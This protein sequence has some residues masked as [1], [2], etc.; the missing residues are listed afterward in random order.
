M[1]KLFTL[2]RTLVDDGA[3][4]LRSSM[5][6]LHLAL[7]HAS[8]KALDPRNEI[9]RNE[10]ARLLANACTS[11]RSV[12]E[13]IDLVNAELTSAN[14]ALLCLLELLERS[15]TAQL[16]AARLYCLLAPIARQY[17]AANSAVDSVACHWKDSPHGGRA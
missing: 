11:A 8:C 12:N 16:S 2:D 3:D 10:L 1:S 9:N 7:G 15:E 17:R 13:L 14:E 6:D 5:Q 4:N